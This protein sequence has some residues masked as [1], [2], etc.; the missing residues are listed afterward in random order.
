MNLSHCTA[1]NTSSIISGG[2]YT[3]KLTPDEGYE[4]VRSGPS[5]GGVVFGGDS[6]DG[7]DG[8]DGTSGRLNPLTCTI[9]MH[10]ENVTTEA[11]DIATGEIA[12]EVIKGDIAIIVEEGTGEQYPSSR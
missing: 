10:D 9:V 8:D 4:F 3:N 7:D 2:S 1:R 12:I 5:L 6:N 11:F